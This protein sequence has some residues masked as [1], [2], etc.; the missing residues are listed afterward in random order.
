MELLENSMFVLE[1]TVTEIW[2][3]TMT[4]GPLATDYI[5]QI[6]S[7][8]ESI[9][10]VHPNFWR[11][12]KGFGAKSVASTEELLDRC[13]EIEQELPAPA[14]MLIHGDFNI[15][16][17][18]YS[19]EDQRVHFIDLY[20]CRE[21]DY[22]QDVSVFL[23]SNFRIPFFAANLRRSLNW[24]I[25]RFYGFADGF[26]KEHGDETFQARLALGLARSFITSTRFELNFEFAREM[27]LRGH[28]LM[29]KML[30]H[31]GRPWNTFQ[32]PVNV[33]YY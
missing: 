4:P 1:Q 23:I 19:H 22:V 29:E 11:S 10:N 31:R 32:L 7:R 14:S 8:L 28:F 25:E 6:K 33:L 18:V 13:M 9:M 12:A 3:Q 16:N 24:I 2:T 20:R 15:N 17:V 5:Q 26:A 27:F 21:M 30:M